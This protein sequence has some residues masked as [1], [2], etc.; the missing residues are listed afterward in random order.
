[1]V[2]LTVYV[3]LLAAAKPLVLTTTLNALY[4]TKRYCR[5]S[6]MGSLAAAVTVTLL[7]PHE[8][9]AVTVGAKGGWI[10][11]RSLRCSRS[12]SLMAVRG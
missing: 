10:G 2:A 5:A 11:C 6:R 1:M 12:T 3:T 4:S 8:V 7:T 9:G